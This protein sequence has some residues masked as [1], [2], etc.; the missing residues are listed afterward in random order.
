[1]PIPELDLQRIEKWCVAEASPLHADELRVEADVTPTAVTIVETRPPW[2][3]SDGVRMRFPIARLRYTATTRQW[4]LCWR[5]RHLRFHRYDRVP[6]ARHVQE[7][8]DFVAD[9]GD[10]IFWG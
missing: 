5:D 2:D 9:S 4:T 6:A 8:L 1:M 3:G 7:L 10:P